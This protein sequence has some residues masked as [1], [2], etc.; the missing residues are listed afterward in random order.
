[1]SEALL[2]ANV[3]IAGADHAHTHHDEAATWIERHGRPFATCAITQG[4]LLRHLIRAGASAPAAIDALRSI[5]TSE[6]HRFWSCDAEFSAGTLRGVVGHRQVTDA[7]LA[8]MARAR[9]A[10]LATF[11]LGLAAVHPDVVQLIRT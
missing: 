2:D 4:A 3:L 5:T 10:R 1:V 8:A 7:Y 9:D 6:L 11:D